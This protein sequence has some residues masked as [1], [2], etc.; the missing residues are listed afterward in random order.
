MPA[1]LGE[2]LC[3][4]KLLIIII[5]VA[6]V[7]TGTAQ[8]IITG[9]I[10]DARTGEPLIGATVAPKSSNELGAAT[11]IDGHFTLSTQ[12]RLPLTLSV[13]YIGYRSLAAS[14]LIIN[15]QLSIVNSTLVPAGAVVHPR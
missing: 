5:A 9:H 6:S 3:M 12:V 2:T 13:N 4:K 15:Y 1:P 14:P 8:T 10:T 7:L 11:D